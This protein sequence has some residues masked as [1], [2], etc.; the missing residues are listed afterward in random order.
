MRPIVRIAATSDFLIFWFLVFDV[1]PASLV[2]FHTPQP[3][4]QEAQK[5]PPNPKTVRKFSQECLAKKGGK[6]AQAPNEAG[7]EN[8]LTEN[9]GWT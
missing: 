1:L 2:E 8:D 6:D 4:P 5:F 9:W 7:R 3:L